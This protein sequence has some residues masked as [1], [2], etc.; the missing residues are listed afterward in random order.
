M[1]KSFKSFISDG[2]SLD[3]AKVSA[4]VVS[5]ILTLICGLWAQ[6]KTGS[7]DPTLG[8]VLKTMIVS[9]AGINGIKIYGES[10]SSGIDEYEE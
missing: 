3:E 9:I 6:Y 8:S 4:L 1:I 2:L 10:T 7:F 5:F